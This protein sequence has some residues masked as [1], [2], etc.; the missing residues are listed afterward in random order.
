VV[1]REGTKLVVVDT[2][3]NTAEAT[4]EAARCADLV[5]LPVAADIH[6][7]ETLPAMHNVLT[8]AG[9]PRAFVVI[10][11]APVQGP[12]EA[13]TRKAVQGMGFEVCPVVWHQRRAFPNAQAGGVAVT[14]YEPEGKAAEESRAL[15]KFTIKL[16]N[17]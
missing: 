3:P 4:I 16:L 10:T 17:S 8:L 12:Y 13:E 9:S 6:D 7:L 2:P 5:L 15:F 14:E 11:R 1:K